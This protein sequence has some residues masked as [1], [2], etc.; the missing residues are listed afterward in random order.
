MKSTAPCVLNVFDEVTAPKRLVTGPSRPG[1]SSTKMWRSLHRHVLSR[2]VPQRS[3][4]DMLAR[5]LPFTNGSV[6]A[7][8]APCQSTSTGTAVIHQELDNSP[9]STGE[10][11]VEKEGTKLS[12]VLANNVVPVTAG[13]FHNFSRHRCLV[14]DSAYRPINVVNWFKALMM[15]EQ[16]KV[17]V[18]E[19]YPNAY[20]VS[21]YRKHPLPAVIRVRQFVDLFELAGKVTLTRRNIMIRDRYICQ[22][23]GARRD[24]TIDHIVPVSK[25]GANTWTNLVTACMHCNQKKANQSLKQMG[26]RLKVEPREPKPYEVGLVLG[27]SQTDLHHPPEYWS[28][29]IQPY[30]EKVDGLH[31]EIA[32]NLAGTPRS[33]QMPVPA[34]LEEIDGAHMAPPSKGPTLAKKIPM[35]GK[36]KKPKRN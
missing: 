16:D 35:P 25:G 20:A 36:T 12:G 14:L 7:A 31:R 33:S 2:A 3:D 9:T 6:K 23:C 10:M 8:I 15:V 34:G 32:E 24:L 13:V 11:G 17:D 1:G 4:C 21:C 5:G 30:K 26:W 29:Y 22:Y 27:I 18:L 28:D 19:L